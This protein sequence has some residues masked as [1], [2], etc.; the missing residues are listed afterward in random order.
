MG[1]DIHKPPRRNGFTRPLHFQ[2]ILSW[3]GYFIELFIYV[4]FIFPCLTR[5]E[6]IGITI[7]YIIL[8]IIYNAV[9]L[10][11][12]VERHKSPYITE[13]EAQTMDNF[14]CRWCEKYSVI[15]AKHC[16]SCNVCR[17]DFDHHCFFLNNC[18][19]FGGNYIYFVVG[20]ITFGISS[21]FTTFL[22]IYVIMATEYTEGEPLDR[23][24]DY[25]GR[26][27]SK[28]LIYF[29]LSCDLL[30]MLGCQIF[31]VY[32]Y[33]LHLLLHIRGISTYTLI[34]YKRQKMLEKKRKMG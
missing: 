11:A 25:Y 29:F 5:N 6:K 7:P 3:I 9:F 14:K 31:M 24:S 1:H 21:I 10:R 18:V 22:C 27:I 13:K 34:Q 30:L 4:I 32:L 28:T 12:T 23:A 2:Q 17:I 26:K 8:I 33:S 19:S 20:I 16:R 15:A